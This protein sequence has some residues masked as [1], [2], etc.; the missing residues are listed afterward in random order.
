MF[1][2]TLVGNDPTNPSGRLI[3]SDFFEKRVMLLYT[4]QQRLAKDTLV[5]ALKYCAMSPLRQRD[6]VG[7]VVR[8]LVNRADTKRSGTISNLIDGAITSSHAIE[9]QY[10]ELCDACEGDSL[11]PTAAMLAHALIDNLGR[12]IT[13]YWALKREMAQGSE[14]LYL[15]KLRNDLSPYCLGWS[16]CGAGGGGFAVAVLKR[17]VT[18]SQF[19]EAI[20]NVNALWRD[21]GLEPRSCSA[22]TAS[23][24]FDGVSARVITN[25]DSDESAVEKKMLHEMLL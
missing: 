25:Q 22:H 8:E 20:E 21:T 10:R 7:D 3:L 18:A 13:T 16:L 5:R 1:L 12:T 9:Q 14:P 19:L 2:K 15:Q 17:E 24:D 4:G 6:V 23:L 11:N